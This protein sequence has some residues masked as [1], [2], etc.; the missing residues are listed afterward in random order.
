MILTRL[1]SRR[2]ST[3]STRLSSRNGGTG[4]TIPIPDP[5]LDANGTG[6]E[7]IPIGKVTVT[8][9]IDSINIDL[10]GDG[11]ADRVIDK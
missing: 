3:R 6:F 9:D 7:D 10:D 8:E 1:S 2:R 11:Q 4:R 5:I